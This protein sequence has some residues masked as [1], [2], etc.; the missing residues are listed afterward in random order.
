M[1]RRSLG[2]ERDFAGV[3]MRIALCRGSVLR[4]RTAMS[5]LRRVTTYRVS[6]TQDPRENRLTEITAAV[7]ERVDRLALEVVEGM[8]SR[9]LVTRRSR[10]ARARNERPRAA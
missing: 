1:S 7:L 9:T 5:L 4:Y 3:L 10:R 8:L 6:P 2:D